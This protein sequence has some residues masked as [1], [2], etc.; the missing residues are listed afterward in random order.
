MHDVDAYIFWLP[1]FSFLHFSLWKR[2]RQKK[3]S[4]EL[5]SSSQEALGFEVNMATDLPPFPSL[6]LF[7]SLTVTQRPWR[8][9]KYETRLEVQAPFPSDELRLMSLASPQS[10]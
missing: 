8:R 4:A 2:S 7:M 3:C 1:L 9:G 10:V 5:L 6:G